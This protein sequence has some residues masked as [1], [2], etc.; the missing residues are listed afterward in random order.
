[1]IDY[2]IWHL[3]KV[4]EIQRKFIDGEIDRA[5][6]DKLLKEENERYS[7]DL[8]AKIESSK[9]KLSENAIYNIIKD[10]IFKGSKQ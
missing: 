4:I 1:M 2:D 10:K 6:L 9:S 8:I 3:T 5:E 7:N